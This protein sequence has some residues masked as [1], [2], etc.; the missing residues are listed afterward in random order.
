M[1]QLHQM[2]AHAESV[3]W[4]QMVPPKL[5]V[6]PAASVSKPK[7]SGEAHNSNG[8]MHQNV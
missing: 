2:W 3:F 8:S 5:Q 1:L 7:T 6:I 4:A